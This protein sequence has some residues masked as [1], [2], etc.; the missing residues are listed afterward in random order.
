MTEADIVASRYQRLTRTR[1]HNRR[2]EGRRLLVLGWRTSGELIATSNGALSTT[3]E[4]FFLEHAL[5]SGVFT[6]LLDQGPRGGV[7]GVSTG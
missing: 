5:F 1:T 7:G 6:K 2:P 3:L 4:V